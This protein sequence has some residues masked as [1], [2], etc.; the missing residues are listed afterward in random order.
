MIIGIALIIVCCIIALIWITSEV[1]KFKHKVWAFVLI[2]LIIFGYISFAVTTR[3]QEIDY[4][5]FSGIMQAFKVYFSWLGSLFGNFK[6][7]TG[8][9]IKMDWGVEGNSTG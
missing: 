9:A 5:S 2:A 1:R 7:L 8:S 6:A 3:N 4:T